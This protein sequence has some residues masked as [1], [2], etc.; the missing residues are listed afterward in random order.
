MNPQ[1]ETINGQKAS[2]SI[3]DF[4]P[5]EKLETGKNSASD[6]Y[7]ITEYQWV[8]N[9]LTITP[10]VY[11]DNSI[12][13]TTAIKI[14]S[15]SKPEGVMQ[16][17][18]I[19]ERSIDVEENRIRPGYSLVIGGMRKTEK[20][21]V[22]RGI[23]FLKDLPIL[24]ALFS[25]RDFE[26]KGTEIIFILTPSISSGSREHRDV[27]NEIQIRFADPDVK[28]GLED[29]LKDPLGSTTYTNIVEKEAAQ[30]GIDRV[31]AELLRQQTEDKAVSEKQLAD[32]AAQEAAKLRQE[33]ERLESQAQK[34]LDEAKKA[35]QRTKAA[36]TTTEQE[37]SKA[38]ELEA[39][40]QQAIK[41]AENANKASQQAKV[42]AAEAARKAKQ[43][44]SHAKQALE[45]AHEAKEAAR[46][47]SEKAAQKA[48]EAAEEKARKEAE[49]KVRRQA[50]KKALKEAEEKARREA[51]EQQRQHQQELPAQQ[52]PSNSS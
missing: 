41:E 16:R 17:S 9:I 31:K 48:K 19:T 27:I 15:R 44:E 50:E 1:I 36:Q 43:Q 46:I 52:S 34:E 24:G 13:L 5:I 18:I 8:E 32:E 38:S 12:G 14:G 11:A 49:E 23:P 28:Q 39:Q 33:A 35:V 21:D 6:A 3:K 7:N 40:K 30:A 10:F 51:E 37:R 25:S 22:V 45:E 4:A 42:A 26:E 47:A 20:R 29:I 2:V